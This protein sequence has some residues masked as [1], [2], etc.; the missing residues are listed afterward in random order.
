MTRPA[1]AIEMNSIEN[2]FNE[3]HDKTC[4]KFIAKTTDDID[5]VSI[6]NL[7]TGCWSAVGKI[8][9]KQVLINFI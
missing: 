6:Q 7:P 1:D 4:I 9:N 8:G 5:Y 2:A 3:F